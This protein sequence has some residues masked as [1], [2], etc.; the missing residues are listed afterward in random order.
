MYRLLTPIEDSVNYYY[1]RKYGGSNGEW[2]TMDEFFDQ[3]KLAVKLCAKYVI[4]PPVK[5]KIK[6]KLELHLSYAFY[7]GCK[8]NLSS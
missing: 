2:V 3:A 8:G 7:R 4:V 1:P 6:N 5:M